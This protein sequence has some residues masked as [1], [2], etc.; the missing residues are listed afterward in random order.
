MS[1][2]KPSKHGASSLGNVKE[3]SE[4]I[5]STPLLKPP[6]DVEERDLDSEHDI[7]KVIQELEIQ[8]LAIKGGDITP[9]IEVKL[10]SEKK[11]NLANGNSSE[12]GIVHMEEHCPTKQRTE[13]EVDS[14]GVNKQERED[15]DKGNNI[16]DDGSA[17]NVG[18]KDNIELTHVHHL[19]KADSQR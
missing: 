18:S 12:E 16:G 11:Q 5:E 2:E 3:E 17:N 15:R 7:D 9:K 13:L 19:D 10:K 4:Q 1:W 14:E 6:T 8:R